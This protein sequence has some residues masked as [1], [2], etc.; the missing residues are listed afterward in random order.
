MC[1]PPPP[2][3]LVAHL[4]MTW[5]LKG[6][7]DLNLPND[8]VLSRAIELLFPGHFGAMEV[9]VLYCIV[10]YCIVL[11]CIVLYCIV[12]YC[13]VLYCIVLYCIKQETPHM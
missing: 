12:L 6:K 9:Y 5:K 11:Y 1:Y 7:T 4:L 10:L 8:F 2:S 13:I 3:T